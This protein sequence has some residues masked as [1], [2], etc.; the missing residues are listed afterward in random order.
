MCIAQ[1]GKVDVTF[2]TLDDGIIGDGFDLSVRT[3]S[4]Q[5]DQNLIVG[6]E[7]LNL[8]GIPAPYLTRLKPDGTTDETFHIGAGFNGKIYASCLQAD[9]KIIVAG[10][11]TLFNGIN[12]GRIIRLNS[13]GSYD[14]SFNTTI[15]ATTGIIYD[16]T[17]QPDGKILIVGSFTK[18]N[19]STVNRVARL[20]PNGSLDTSFAI[21]IGSTSNIM[22]AKILSEGRILLV[23]N[24]DKFNGI[25]AN[26]IICLGADGQVDTN[27]LAGS[28][29]NDDV[30]VAIIQPDGKILLGGKFTSYNGTLANRIIRINNDGS[31]DT[32]FF[33]G[34]GF[35]DGAVV[36]LKQDIAGNLMVGGSFTGSYNGEGVNRVCLLNSNGRLLNDIDFGAGPATASVYALENDVEGSWYIGGS[37]LVF[38]GLNQGRLAKINA[39]HEYD[40]GY[41]SSGIGFDNS[42]YKVIPLDNR[43]MIVCGNFKKFNGEMVSRITKLSEDGTVDATFNMAQF[44]ANN[45]IKTADIQLDRKIIIGGNFTRYNDT[46]LNRILRIQSDGSIDPTFNIGNGANSQIYALS[47]QPDQKVIIAGNFTRF[48]DLPAGRIIRLLPDGS[49]DLTFNSSGTDA[50]IEV[51]LIQPD[52]KILIGGRFTNFNGAPVSHLVRLNP[53]GSTDS[54]FAIGD[55]FDK[56]VYALALQSDGKIIVGGNFLSFNRSSQKRI[57]RLNANGSLDTTFDSGTGFSKGDVRSILIQP[58]DRILVGGTFSG[59][60][61]NNSSLRLVRLLKSG[62]FDNSFDA[63]LNNKLFTMGIT[64]DYRLIIGGDFNSVSGI[65]KHRI[66]RLKLC[67]GSTSWDGTNWSNGFPS[68]GKEAFFKE[69]YLGLTGTNVCSCT[70]DEGK[71]VNLL[72]GNTLSIEFGYSGSGILTL[73]NSACLYQTDD[74]MVNT[75]IIQLKRITTPM[76]RYDFTHWSSPVDHQ[77]L[78]DVSPNTL[79]DKYFSYDYNVKNWKLESPSNEMV[80]GIGYIIRAPQYYSITDRLE[81]EAVFKG[82][83]NNGKITTRVGP[84][85]S[86]TLIGNPYPSTLNADA[87]LRK[88]SSLLKGG[89]YFWTHNTPVTNL[90]YTADDYAVY[91]LLGGVGTR[92][93]LSVGK[94]DQIPDGKIATGEAFFVFSTARGEIEFNNSMR[95]IEN[96][97]FFFK[98]AKKEE[99]ISQS[100]LEKH[101]VWLNFENKEG[102]F[103]QILIGYTEG[104][105]NSFDNDFDAESME[106]NTFGDFFSSI[107]D[108]KLVIQGRALPFEK[109]DEVALGYRSSIE[110]DFTISIDHEDG[111]LITSDIFIEDTELN[112][113]HDLK[114]EPYAFKT[115]KGNFD[116]RFVLKYNNATLSVIDIKDNNCQISVSVKDQIIKIDACEEIIKE[117]EV[118]DISGRLV[119]RKDKVQ[120][121]NFST[122]KLQFAHQILLLK[123]KLENGKTETRKIIV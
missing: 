52:G 62:G 38:D 94:V 16:I 32:T 112:K 64:S 102:F 20:L 48:N 104:A 28:G 60:F 89:L 30:S 54:N 107:E 96:N 106:G 45:L 67:L 82:I 99:V 39:D 42:V 14:S 9:G 22:S 120:S 97:S 12:A 35:T 91:N 113:I 19:N 23:G 78:V 21:G 2:N 53:D 69:D 84:L 1:Q 71:N 115:Q 49:R 118:F 121:S 95:Q 24:F 65:S 105:T 119:Y 92:K 103:K 27:F 122:S 81:Y 75:G 51:L 110:G 13:D 56:N 44:G 55:G 80:P 7:F 86:A 73:E 83:P 37:F 76:S 111:Y 108:K 63:R 57:V 8:N 66:A 77:K 87:F 58:D 46:A 72:S 10:S 40:T 93:S 68:G 47:I 5:P 25:S 88:N 50:V 74:D 26:R 4:M 70:I 34:S 117:I 31:V 98:P 17:S 90:K 6:G 109:S 41:L 123:I 18:Y 3:L 100:V 101:R 15:G 114:T 43:K 11:F 79:A 61:K 36:A 33:A 59:T 85:D 116:K 29:F